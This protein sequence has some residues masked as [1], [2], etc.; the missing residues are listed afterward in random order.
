TVV[1]AVGLVVLV[2]VAHEVGEREAVVAG[3]EVDA[4]VRQ[5]C[6][7]REEVARP[8]KARR[9]VTHEAGIGAPEAANAVAEARVPFRPAGG[10]VA[11]LPAVGTEVPWLRDELHLRQ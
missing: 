7:R 1:L 6:A 11:D 9:E 4:G 8:R 3:D 5:A 10:E 2:L